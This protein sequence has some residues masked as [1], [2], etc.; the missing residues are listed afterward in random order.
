MSGKS[1]IFAVQY[2]RSL[3]GGS[4]PI[5]V[6]ASDGLL[7]VVKFT[8]NLQ[9][10]N[11]PFNESIGS[12]IYRA[13]GL[14]GPRWKPLLVSDSF[15]DS[16]RDC[17]IQ[18]PLG[19]LRPES[20]LCFGSCFLGGQGNRLLEILPA[21][22]FRRVRNHDSF[23]LAW[24]IDICAGHA[25]NR[26][27]IFLED[28][29]GWLDPFFVDHG[30]LFGGPEGGL[31]RGFLASRYLDPR[32]YQR[33]TSEQHLA[34]RKNA[35]GLDVDQLWKGIEALPHDWKTTSALSEYAECLSRLS[36]S[37]LLQNI[38]DTMLCTLARDNG[39]ERLEPQFG[40]K[41]PVAVLRPGV[42]ATKLDCRCVA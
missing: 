22:S 41:P 34:I 9:G 20:G 35:G 5:L 21:T 8:N 28:G 29:A 11:L 38:V 16:N 24:L 37:K 40:R 39:L 23:W 27:A 17:W 14:P 15:I 31:R 7:Y 2:L 32:I 1:L 19:R 4:Q 12:E 36:D 33:L 25:D 42:Q 18:T 10:P 30:H 13:C 6:R 3:R 26:Q